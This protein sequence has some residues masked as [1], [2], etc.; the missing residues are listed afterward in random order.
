MQETSITGS[1][2]TIYTYRTVKNKKE[3]EAEGEKKEELLHWFPSQNSYG[4]D[5]SFF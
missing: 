1:S 3:T 5:C 4:F 2:E